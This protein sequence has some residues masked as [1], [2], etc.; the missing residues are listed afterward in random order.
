MDVAVMGEARRSAGRQAGCRTGSQGHTETV[1]QAD[2]QPGRGLSGG[3]L[4]IGSG[5]IAA[6][7]TTGAR[8]CRSGS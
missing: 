6:A 7:R 2:P 3:K 4:A 8:C 5:A 1:P